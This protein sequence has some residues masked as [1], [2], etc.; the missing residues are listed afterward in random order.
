MWK[1]IM[2][3]MD[4][5]FKDHGSCAGRKEPRAQGSMFAKS[6]DTR[7]DCAGEAIC[8]GA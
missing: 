2:V 6:S 8:I 1:I 5:M 7:R 4:V 3:T